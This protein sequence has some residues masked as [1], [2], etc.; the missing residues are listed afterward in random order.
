MT[1]TQTR[2]ASGGR[3]PTAESGE[4]GS[5][6]RYKLDLPLVSIE[7]R[8]PDVRMP[9]VGLPH[10][11]LP[12]APRL[13]RQELGHAVDVARSFLPPP[14]RLAYYGGLGA[15][16]VAGVVSW[17]VAAAI[18]VG[19]VIAQ[20]GRAERPGEARRRGPTDASPAPEG[21]GKA[22]ESVKTSPSAQR[23]EPATAT[24]RT[25]T[26]RARSRG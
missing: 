7:V 4:R 20:R 8:P 2:R 13:N 15:L 12:R 25:T 19:T 1:V 9:H 10:V 5:G 14:E 22:A 11:D 21:E 6:R 3:P 17:P 18:G 23:R 26:T 24:R 16:A